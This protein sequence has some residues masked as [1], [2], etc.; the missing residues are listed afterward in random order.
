[1]A[2]VDVKTQNNAGSIGSFH[3][4]GWARNAGSIGAPSTDAKHL[5]TA[6]DGMGSKLVETFVGAAR[7]L[8]DMIVAQ[9]RVDV[10]ETSDA[11]RAPLAPYEEQSH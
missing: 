10:V 2:F 1:M 5:V 6:L 3:G 8:V 9:W 4:I 11:E 7:A